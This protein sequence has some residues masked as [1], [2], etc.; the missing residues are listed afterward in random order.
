MESPFIP[1]S[2]SYQFIQIKKTEIKNHLMIL[3]NVLFVLLQLV[4]AQTTTYIG[5][6]YCDDDNEAC[7][8]YSFLFWDYT[9]V[10][11]GY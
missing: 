3:H 9:K 4:Q 2:T 5:D 8:A 6:G 10:R 7:E 11:D 1:Q